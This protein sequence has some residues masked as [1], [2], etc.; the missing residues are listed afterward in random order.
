M[1]RTLMTRLPRLFR[2]ELVLES[3]GKNPLAANIIIFGIILGDFLF[4]ILIRYVVCTQQNRL[5]I[6]ENRKDIPIMPPDLAL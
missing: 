3:L 6:K 4:F 5:D 2:V 1:A